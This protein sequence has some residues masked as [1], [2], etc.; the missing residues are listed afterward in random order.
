MNEVR[1]PE[2]TAPALEAQ[3]E[4]AIAAHRSVAAAME[5]LARDVTAG[6]L[7]DV[8]AQDEYAHDVVVS[9]GPSPPLYLAYAAT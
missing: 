5:W 3:V 9:I 7:V 1:Y 6:D 2:S 8:I 4:R